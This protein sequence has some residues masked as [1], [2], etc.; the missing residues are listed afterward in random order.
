MNTE[1]RLKREKEFHN[2]T[3][4]SNSRQAAKKYYKSASASKD[5][6]LAKEYFEEINAKYFNLFATLSSFIPFMST[7]LNKVD[8]SIF[9]IAPFFKKYAWIVVLEFSK[10]R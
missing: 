10:P 6:D 2:E 9:Q 3:F 8:S 1:D 4:S 7:F 5:F